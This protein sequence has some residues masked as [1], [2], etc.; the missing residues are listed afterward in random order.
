MEGLGLDPDEESSHP[1]G[2]LEGDERGVIDGKSVIFGTGTEDYLNS[3]F[4]FADGA[5]ATPFAQAQKSEAETRGTVVGCR[6]HILSDAIDFLS[7]FDFDL[8][9]GAADPTM[10]DR[11]RSVAFLYQ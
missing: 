9:I 3:S 2:F 5:F 4:Y 11:Y 10:L 7:S 8:E 1:L 6:W